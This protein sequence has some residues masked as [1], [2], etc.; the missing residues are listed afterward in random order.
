MRKHILQRG[1]TPGRGLAEMFD[2]SGELKKSRFKVDSE[3]AADPFNLKIDTQLTF[4]DFLLA[5]CACALVRY[6]DPL[7]SFPKRLEMFFKDDFEPVQARGRTKN[8]L[9]LKVGDTRY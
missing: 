7:A 8:L 6:P 5:L 1:G 4:P 9:G 3:F 2:L